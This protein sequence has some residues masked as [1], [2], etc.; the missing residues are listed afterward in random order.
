MLLLFVRFPQLTLREPKD[1]IF[2]IRSMMSLLMLRLVVDAVPR[3]GGQ[4]GLRSF[5]GPRK[6]WVIW[7]V[8]SVV[9]SNR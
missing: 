4:E 9:A 2:V 1:C 6:D 5:Q 7:L 8:Y 3:R